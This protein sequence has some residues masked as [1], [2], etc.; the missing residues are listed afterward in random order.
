MFAKKKTTRFLIILIHHY[1]LRRDFDKYQ[2]LSILK[3][4]SSFFLMIWET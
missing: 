4:W 1:S 3:V 2:L